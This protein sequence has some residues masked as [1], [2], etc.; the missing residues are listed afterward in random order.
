MLED[1]FLA[2]CASLFAGEQKGAV[3]VFPWEVPRCA[4]PVPA[5]RRNLCA[6][7]E[8]GSVSGEGSVPSG[9]C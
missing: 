3:H 4:P 9:L 8:P 2:G 7:P 5:G 1:L 6:V